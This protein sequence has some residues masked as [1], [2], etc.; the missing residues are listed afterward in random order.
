MSSTTDNI[1]VYQNL[2]TV[3]DTIERDI[4]NV[5]R[6]TDMEFFEDKNGNGH[7]DLSNVPDD[8]EEIVGLRGNELFYVDTKPDA[9]AGAP[10]SSLPDGLSRDLNAVPYFYAPT[11]V[12][13][14][15]YDGVVGWDNEADNSLIDGHRRDEF[16]FRTFTLIRGESRPVMVHYRLRIPDNNPQRPTLLRTVSFINRSTDTPFAEPPRIDE[17]ADGITDLEFEMF[18]KESRIHDR[19]QFLDAKQ[20]RAVDSGPPPKAVVPGLEN[21]FNATAVSL[22]YTGDAI[23]ENTRENGVWLRPEDTNFQFGAV[24]P[25]DRFYLYD[26]EDDD[27]NG[28]DTELAAQFGRKFLTIEQIIALQ[29]TG[30][31]LGSGESK[32]FIKFVETIDFSVLAG[33]AGEA[34]T[35]VTEFSEPDKKR[36]IYQS[37]KVKF[38]VGFLPGAFKVKFKYRDFRA[39][40][41]KPFSR[42]IRVL[43]S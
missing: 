5:V 28:N 32:I 27:G 11:L 2:R 10:D 24:R 30:N 33:L 19:G 14:S 25:G 17:L 39:R 6:T 35:T 1:L 40:R 16:Y 26:A 12:R 29:P 41:L 31:T 13:H 7:Y 9:G 18:Y 4:A 21:Q 37:F 22:Y 20:L 38:R 23:I 3:L 43:G 8:A 36:T 42:V 34:T 15:N